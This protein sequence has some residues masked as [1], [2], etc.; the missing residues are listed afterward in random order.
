MHNLNESCIVVILQ[1]LGPELPGKDEVNVAVRVRGI[2][3]ADTDTRIRG[4]D[5]VNLHA[6]PKLPIPSACVLRL[7]R[8]GWARVVVR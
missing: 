7:I 2:L 4:D 6:C 1:A 8:L 5:M 3:L